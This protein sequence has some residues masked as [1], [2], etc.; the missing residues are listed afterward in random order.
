[1]FRC[2]HSIVRRPMGSRCSPIVCSRPEKLSVSENDKP[3]TSS[4]AIDRSPQ[5]L[6]VLSGEDIRVGP[7]DLVDRSVVRGGLEA[8]QHVSAKQRKGIRA[9]ELVPIFFQP[10]RRRSISRAP[11][12]ADHF[13]IG[14]R[15]TPVLS[16]KAVEY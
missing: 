1:M 9:A 16:G 2:S 15:S 11:E 7:P 6:V 14:A 5:A 3:R 12:Q 13:A 4:L 10:D 8:V